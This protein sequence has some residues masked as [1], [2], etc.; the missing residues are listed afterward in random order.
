VV[1]TAYSVRAQRFAD[2]TLAAY[3]LRPDEEIL[4]EEICE[5]ITLIDTQAEKVKKLRNP[6]PRLLEALQRHRGLLSRLIR[7][8]GLKDQNGGTAQ[9]EG[10]TTTNARKAAAARWGN[11][12]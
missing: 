5:E 10:N 4:L 7:Q 12:G 11:R 2:S 3:N 9:K 8:L 1:N 6:D